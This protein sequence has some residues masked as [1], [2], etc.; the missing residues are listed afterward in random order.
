[1]QSLWESE[2]QAWSTWASSVDSVYSEGIAWKV[3]F[4]TPQILT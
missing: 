4:I 1:M 2:Q 3:F